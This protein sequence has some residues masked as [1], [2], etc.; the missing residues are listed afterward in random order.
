MRDLW[1]NRDNIKC[2]NNYI[3]E[4]IEEKKDREKEAENLSEETMAENFPS[5]MKE[6]DIQVQVSWRVPMMN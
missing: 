1:D 2:T 3:T 6:T 5:L 4:V